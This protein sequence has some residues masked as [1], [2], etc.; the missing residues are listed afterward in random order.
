MV[1]DP[2]YRYDGNGD[3][4]YLTPTEANL[5]TAAEYGKNKLIDGI[6]YYNFDLTS[7]TLTNFN[8]CDYFKSFNNRDTAN[9]YKGVAYTCYAYLIKDGKVYLSKAENVNFYELAMEDVTSTQ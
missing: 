6:R 3:V 8:R 4:K 1:M 5:I 9:N 7:L 2:N